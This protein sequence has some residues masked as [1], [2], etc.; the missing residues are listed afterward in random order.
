MKIIASAEEFQTFIQQPLALVDF[1]APWC[2][3]CRVLMPTVE[4]L[5]LAGYKV[6]KVN[7]DELG[8]LLDPYGVRSIPALLLFKNGQLVDQK[9]GAKWLY[10]QLH[11]WMELNQ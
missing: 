10:H 7:I 2:G 4:R 1:Y 6:A 3:P 11:N 5:S 9:L 8:V